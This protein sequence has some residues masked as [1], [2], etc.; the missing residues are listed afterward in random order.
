MVFL[1]PSP[2]P[3]PKLHLVHE[4]HWNSDRVDFWASF[5]Q[6]TNQW[7]HL[8]LQSSTLTFESICSIVLVEILQLLFRVVMSFLPL[9]QIVKG[10][11]SDLF[12]FF[13]QCIPSH[14]TPNKWPQEFRQ[15]LFLFSYTP[16]NCYA[17][18]ILSTRS[19]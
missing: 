1:S 3:H 8:N 9:L 18:L 15:V 16:I 7:S 6:I 14:F 12:P 13:L 4:N 11:K 2:T 10:S 5:M 19:K 17:D